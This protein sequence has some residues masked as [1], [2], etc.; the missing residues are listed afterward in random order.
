MKVVKG[1]IVLRDYCGI[2][3]HENWRSVF[4]KDFVAEFLAVKLINVMKCIFVISP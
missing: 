2:M 1:A 4:V 3:F